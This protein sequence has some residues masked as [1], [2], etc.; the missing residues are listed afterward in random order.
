M[1]F[2]YKHFFP[3][4]KNINP[5]TLFNH[6]VWESQINHFEHGLTLS[7]ESFKNHPRFL[8]KKIRSKK[9]TTLRQ[10]NL[11]EGWEEY[12]E[13]IKFQIKNFEKKSNFSLI[14]KLYFKFR[15]ILESRKKNRKNF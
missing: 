6:K 11:G 4:L 1:Y 10:I 9:I 3:K 2:K 12:E 8:D 5:I 14:E 15:R 13:N 7:Y